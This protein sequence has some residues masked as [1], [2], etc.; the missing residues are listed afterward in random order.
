MPSTSAH[1]PPA[2]LEELD[3]LAVE[4]GVSRNRLIV[5]ACREILR[6][7]QAWPKDI[8][9]NKRFAAKDLADLQAS[10]KGFEKDLA[11]ARRTRNAPPF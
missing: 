11:A 7:R 10:A 4:K 9:D 3:H 1:F 6:Q 5:E 2:L 8:F